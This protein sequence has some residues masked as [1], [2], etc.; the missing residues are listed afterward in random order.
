MKKLLIVV[1]SC[2]LLAG[3]T[4]Y[5]EA[6]IIKKLEKKVDKVQGYKIKGMLTINNGDDKYT[7]NVDV[8]Y[9][10]KDYFRVS[11]QNKSNNHEQI[12]LKNKDGVYVLTPSLNKSFK[13]QSDWPYNNSQIY[14]IQTLITD[15]K[16]D[17]SYTV[18]KNKSGYVITSKVNYSNNENLIS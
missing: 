1:L 11:L 4:K 13:F 17:S 14:L 9:K 15:I 2:F 16:N 18:E 12:I 8:S 7:Y 5:S 6:G 3:C 10:K